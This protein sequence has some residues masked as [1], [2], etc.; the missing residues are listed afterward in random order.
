MNNSNNDSICELMAENGNMKRLL[1]EMLKD[2]E[3]KINER[4]LNE[5][6]EFTKDFE[7]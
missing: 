3:D 2:M 6:R 7:I 4:F 1:L 5:M